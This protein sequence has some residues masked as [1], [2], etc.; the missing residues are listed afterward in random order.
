MCC[1]RLDITLDHFGFELSDLVALGL[2]SSVP[3]QEISWQ[4]RLQDDLFC[5]QLDVKCSVCTCGATAVDGQHIYMHA[6]N[7]RCLVK[8]YGSLC[9]CPDTITATVVELE[10]V[11]MDEVCTL[12]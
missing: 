10:S 8:Q 1:F 11:S 5:V 4:E 12:L 9:D 3:C 2:V 7:I 6:V